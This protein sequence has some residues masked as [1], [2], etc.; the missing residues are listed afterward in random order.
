MR[1]H[2]E[3]L[4]GPSLKLDCPSGLSCV[5]VSF[6]PMGLCLWGSS[7]PGESS[8]QGT[9]WEHQ[10][11]KHQSRIRKS[12]FTLMYQYVTPFTFPK[13]PVDNLSCSC[14][15][16][17]T[18]YIYHTI[19]LLKGS[20]RAEG[21]IGGPPVDDFLTNHVRETSWEVQSWWWLQPLPRTPP[22]LLWH[23]H[24]PCWHPRR[25][26]GAVLEGW[27]QPFCWEN[28]HNPQN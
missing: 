14:M 17:I 6:C 21:S 7:L 8:C 23:Q 1:N 13:M 25:R 22:V 4:D 9:E 20:R 24:P 3:S 11:T 16:S 28:K 12:T 27:A 10:M 15:Y 26:G 2:V 18:S 19:S 5:L